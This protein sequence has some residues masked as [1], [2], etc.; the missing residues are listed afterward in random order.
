MRIIAKSTL[1]LFWEMYPIAKNS[2]I[3][4]YNIIETAIWENPNDV[5]QTF[6]NASILG[7]RRI[8]FNIKGNDFRLITEISYKLKIV[9]IVWVGN[10]TDYD[11]IDAKNIQYEK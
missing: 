2:L 11:K 7:E 3:E 9:F 5:K 1:K 4:W 10:H 6:G 8:V